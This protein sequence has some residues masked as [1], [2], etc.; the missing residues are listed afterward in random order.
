MFW[1]SIRMNFTIHAIAQMYP[2]EYLKCSFCKGLDGAYQSKVTIADYV[3]YMKAQRPRTKEEEQAG[4]KTEAELAAETRW[5]RFMADVDAKVAD[6]WTFD[7]KEMALTNPSGAKMGL[8]PPPKPGA[9]INT[10]CMCARACLV[11]RRVPCIG[12]GVLKKAT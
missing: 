8:M 10:V 11:A 6:G 3:R 5:N 4:S 2:N 12:F 1:D 9:L 7:D